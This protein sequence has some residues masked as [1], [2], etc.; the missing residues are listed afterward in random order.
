MNQKLDLIFESKLDLIF[1][2][3]II[4]YE[5]NQKLDLIL[6]LGNQML[7]LIFVLKIIFYEMPFGN[8]KLDLILESKVGFNICAK[9]Y[10]LRNE[11]NQIVCLL[12]FRINLF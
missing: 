8:Q 12:S 1:V 6:P 11:S 9:K 4:F 10:I 3:K 2:L 7:D 5:M